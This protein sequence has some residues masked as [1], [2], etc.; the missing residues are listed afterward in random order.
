[1]TLKANKSAALEISSEVVTK[2]IKRKS[3][4][5]T[6]SKKKTTRKRAL[7]KGLSQDQLQ[8]LARKCQ[9]EFQ[10]SALLTAALTHRS[11]HSIN[12]ERLEFLG[13][14]ILGFV[15]ADELYR[16]FPA[17]AEGELSR[18][19]S[20]LVKG[21]ALAKLARRLE[22]GEYLQ[23][24][25]GELKSGGYRRNSI[26]ADAFE[27]VIGAIYLDG[28]LEQ[29]RAF[30]HLNYQDTLTTLTIEDATKDAKTQLQEFLQGRR[31]GLPTYKVVATSGSA[32]QQTFKVSCHVKH[33][34]VNTEG[35]GSS[36]RKAE[37]M[38]ASVAL[39]QIKAK[40]KAGKS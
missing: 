27:A 6:S 20:S 32:H 39:S 22:L 38:A 35:E 2:S 7:P 1:L 36:R 18:C 30:I 14:A 10:D 24:G 23:L 15:I 3:P 13:D 31:L 19:R 34:D 17:A 25:P 33:F 40:Q 21:E 16:R 26:L 9:Y 11:K 37:Q 5:R 4:A 29:A 12:N 8:S 28:G